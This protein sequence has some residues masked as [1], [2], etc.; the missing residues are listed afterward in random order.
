MSSF[1]F[2]FSLNLW[3]GWTPSL[4]L[5]VF[6]IL[7]SVRLKSVGGAGGHPNSIL[8]LGGGGLCEFRM[9]G[10]EP[11]TLHF[12]IIIDLIKGVKH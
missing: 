6:V 9:R 7:G 3:N 11:V 8:D 2:L 10:K 4:T 1:S 12:Q 5:A